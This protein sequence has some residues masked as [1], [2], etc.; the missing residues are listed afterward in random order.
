MRLLSLGINNLYKD[1]AKW[2]ELEEGMAKK[3][4]KQ[5]EFDIKKSDI[6]IVTERRKRKNHLINENQQVQDKRASGL[7]WFRLDNAAM[8]YP[9]SKNEHWTF[10]YRVSAVFKEEIDAEILQKSVDEILP[11]FP[12]FDVCLKNGIFWHY[13]EPSA[14]RLLCERECEMPCAY[15]NLG[16]PRQHLIRVLYSK[17]RL[18]LEVF[19]AISDGHGAMTFLNSLIARYLEN[20]GVKLSSGEGYLNYRDLPTQDEIED[21][22]ITNASGAGGKSHK[23]K[24]A[25]NIRGTVMSDGLVNVTHAIM[26]VENVKEVAAAHKTKLTVLLAAVFCYEILKRRRNSKK[27]IKISIPID[28]RKEFKS[29]TMRNFSS[30]INIE[31]SDEK[32]SLDEIIEIIKNGLKSANREFLQANIDSNVSLQNNPLIKLVPLAIKDVVLSTRFNLLGENLQT[33]AF[34]NLGPVNCPPEFSDHIL[35]YEVNLGRSK[36]NSIAVGVISFGDVLVLTISSKL[37]ENT[38][39]RDVIRKLAELGVKI[40]VESNRRDTYGR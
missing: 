8:V 4:E 14:H 24:S 19:H 17:H 40:K 7:S 11:R 33:F 30:Y 1:F 32:A 36:H 5:L 31:V 35:R 29:V 39:E 10:V 2:Q 6:K 28:L 34:S 21:S 9:S 3:Q 25:Y 22:F 13:F 23:E 12:T 26:S 16:D 38:T 27:P 15:M 20:K 18:S 37:A